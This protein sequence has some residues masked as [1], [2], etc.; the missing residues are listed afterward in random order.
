M[1]TCIYVVTSG[2]W[3]KDHDL[4]DCKHE[5]V[6]PVDF[7]TTYMTYDGPESFVTIGNACSDCGLVLDGYSEDDRLTIITENKLI[8]LIEK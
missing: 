8:E 4:R 2:V 3:L 6:E 1:R 5:K 7:S